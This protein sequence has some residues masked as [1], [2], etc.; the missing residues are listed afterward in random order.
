MAELGPV[1]VTV[2]VSLGTTKL[3]VQPITFEVPLRAIDDHKLTD[4]S[5][6]YTVNLDRT[7]LREHLTKSVRT[8][9]DQVEGAFLAPGAVLLT[10]DECDAQIVS[11]VLATLRHETGGAH[12]LGVPA[13]GL[14]GAFAH[15]ELAVV[16]EAVTPE[17]TTPTDGE[18]ADGRDDA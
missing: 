13:L 10:C 2:S 11:E 3:P 12:S 4:G 6:N 17:A 5:A 1:T 15:G 14:V 16:G 9:A 8:L 7:E 18:Q